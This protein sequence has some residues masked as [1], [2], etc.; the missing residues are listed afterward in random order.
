MGGQVN[1]SE[2]APLFKEYM[3]F[4]FDIK[5]KNKLNPGKKKSAKL[6]M[7]SLYGKTG[8]EDHGSTKLIPISELDLLSLEDLQKP[9]T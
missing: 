6:M 9:S 8:Q 2:P 1:Y 4:F 7:N 5:D 3:E